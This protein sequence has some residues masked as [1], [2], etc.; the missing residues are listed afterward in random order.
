MQ[1][2]LVA[3][4]PIVLGMLANRRAGAAPDRAGFGR[5]A[6]TQGEPG[7]L[8]DLLGGI[9]GGMAGAAPGSGTGTGGL[10]D[11]LEGFRR[12]GYGDQAN[13]WVSRGQNLPIPPDALEQV[14]GR[15]ALGR[16]AQR[17][18]VSEAEAASGLSQLLPEV[19]DRM[20]PEG[21][22]PDLDSLAESV[23]AFAQRYGMR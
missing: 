3:L 15:D 17:A 2:V 11:L 23:D 13:S 18:G 5:N 9:F 4:L 12:A 16:I 21:E 6:G 14:F 10:G 8:G 22:V 20:T 1:R 7:G 19:V